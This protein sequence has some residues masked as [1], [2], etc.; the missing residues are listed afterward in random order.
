MGYLDVLTKTAV[1]QMQRQRT[2][3]QGKKVLTEN[4]SKLKSLSAAP[5]VEGKDEINNY[6]EPVT[7]EYYIPKESRF[8]NEIKYLYIELFDPEPKNDSQKE[9]FEF[10]KKKDEP[11]DVIQVMNQFPK[12]LT[13]ILDH[14][15]SM[16]N[17]YEAASMAFQ[18]GMGE[19]PEKVKKALYI[20]EVLLKNEPTLPSLEILGDHV[21]YN[22]N[23][24][25]R[26]LN[27]NKI[28]HTLEDGT[29]HF[30]IERHRVI[31]ERRNNPV[32][33]RFEIL[34]EIYLEQA[35]PPSIEDLIDSVE[36]ENL[37]EFS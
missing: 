21:T 22:I 32:D 8:A 35:F 26:F 1:N 12:H 36:L 25:V 4:I 14:Y 13:Y 17:M 9:I 27:K 10:F 28:P 3:I 34:A 5:A 31:N 23:W 6:I 11:I 7:I 19:N 24:C 29:V 15:N 20:N 30:L 2:R 18:E 16:M 33:D 37:K